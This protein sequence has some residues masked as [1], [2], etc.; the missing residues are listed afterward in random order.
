MKT[1]LAVAGMSLLLSVA[2]CAK[3]GKP[4]GESSK[5]SNASGAEKGPAPSIMWEDSGPNRAPSPGTPSGSGPAPSRMWQQSEDRGQVPIAT[6]SGSGPAPSA[7]WLSKE[8]DAKS[9]SSAAA[10]D[11][12]PST[13]TAAPATGSRA[14]GTTPPPTTG[15]EGGVSR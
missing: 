6:P 14:P 8:P 15:R 4:D 3:S 11:A 9:P 1:M 12:A 13:G 2:G 5:V 7:F 10:P